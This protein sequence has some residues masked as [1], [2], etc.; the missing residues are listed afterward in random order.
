[1]KILIL[2]DANSVHTYRWAKS[3]KDK[4]INIEIFSLFKDQNQFSPSYKSLGINVTTSNANRFV[5]YKYT[6]NITKIFYVVA[7]RKLKKCLKRFNPQLIH[8]HY[9]S[10]YGILAMLS[11]FRPYYISIWGDDVFLSTKNFI[12]KNLLLSSLK[13]AQQLFSTSHAINDFMKN[14]YGLS[15]KIIPF[16]VETNLVFVLVAAVARRNPAATRIQRMRFWAPVQ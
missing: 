2:S 6:R 11:G 9:L 15:T 10:S 7:L 1:M 3:L 13:N 4:G 12:F 14:H 8:S 16:G 5:F